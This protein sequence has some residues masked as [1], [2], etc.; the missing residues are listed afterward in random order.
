MTTSVYLINKGINKPILFR[1]LQSQ[2]IL[3]A[4]AILVGDLILFAL[5][6][7]AGLSPWI[8][9]PLALALG[10]TGILTVYHLSH[11][12]G[13]YGMLKRRAARCLPQALRSRSRQP[14]IHLQKRGGAYQKL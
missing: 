3:Y 14:F 10:A 12:Y 1:G 13:V 9:L 7:V 8:D 2:Y 11:R 6:H 5:L 4:G